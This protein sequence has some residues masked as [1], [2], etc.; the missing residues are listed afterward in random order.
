MKNYISV[1]ISL[2]SLLLVSCEDLSKPDV[3]E[4]SYLKAT[5]TNTL[6]SININEPLTVT[7]NIPSELQT[8]SNKT[9]T[10]TG[11]NVKNIGGYIVSLKDY[12][13]TSSGNAI[14]G[15]S[16][17]NENGEWKEKIIFN[18]SNSYPHLYSVNFIPKDSG[19]FC[20][21]FNYPLS[22]ILDDADRKVQ[23]NT[24]LDFDVLNKHQEMITNKYSSWQSYIDKL[25]NDKI[26]FYVFY[27]KP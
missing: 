12:D 7:F 13:D 14:H 26:G 22:I 18:Q 5:L 20:L 16:G 10:L 9:Y 23:I 1:F 17:F 19:V 4:K 27:V 11:G 25:N 6:D 15:Y 3:Y 24:Y 21:S 8:I 2:F